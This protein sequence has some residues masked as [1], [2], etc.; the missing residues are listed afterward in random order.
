MTPSIQIVMTTHQLVHL[1]CMKPV[2][3]TQE[4]A[5]MVLPERVDYQ[6]NPF[7]PLDYKIDALMACGGHLHS[8]T[9]VIEAN[10]QKSSIVLPSVR[11][12]VQDEKSGQTL[13]RHEYHDHGKRIVGP[14]GFFA[15]IV[16]GDGEVVKGYTFLTK[17][18]AL[19]E[20]VGVVEGRDKCASRAAHYKNI[21]PGPVTLRL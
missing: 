14:G 12:A 19:D 6:D 5:Y 4:Q 10:G 13:Y 2:N 21:Q 16:N 7:L 17:D 8:P 18:D 11:T 15:E 20:H 3:V 9:S 1:T